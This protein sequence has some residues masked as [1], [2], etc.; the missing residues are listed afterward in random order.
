M[1]KLSVKECLSFGWK[2][3]WSRP[4]LF[5]LAGVIV[6][7]VNAVFS[8][9]EEILNSASEAA[10]GSVAAQ[11]A[12]FSF[13]FSLIGFIVSVYVQ[14]GT[15][16]FSLKAHDD[17]STAHVR[18]LVLL[19]GFWR[20]LGTSVLVFL[21]VVAGLILL[22]VP[23]I[24]LALA[25][26]FALYLSVDTGL[27]PVAALK[28]SLAMTKGHRWSLFVLTLALIGIN[29]LGMLALLIGLVVSIPV[30]MLASVHAYRWL[31]AR[32]AEPSIEIVVEQE[33]ATAVA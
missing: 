31:Q 25:L 15:T 3:F 23:G 10:G 27:G 24:I 28:E 32:R 20:Y 22:I 30:S 12:I 11:L 13:A 18:D 14:M 17:V 4:W 19:K 9:P 16:R 2:T 29:L 8:V 7:A 1:E 26:S 21:A 33:T 5:V 6:F